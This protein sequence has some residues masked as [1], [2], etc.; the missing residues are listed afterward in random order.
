MRGTETWL[1]F[2]LTG[3]LDGHAALAKCQLIVDEGAGVN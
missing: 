3:V 1:S 2:V